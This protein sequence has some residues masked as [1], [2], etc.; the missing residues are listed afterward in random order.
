MSSSV[1]IVYPY[2][3]RAYPDIII[4][5]D[6]RCFIAADDLA[7]KLTSAG[8]KI[9]GDTTSYPLTVHSFLVCKL[10]DTIKEIAAERYPKASILFNLYGDED[11]SLHIN[12]KSIFSEEL[13]IDLLKV[14]GV[15]MTLSNGSYQSIDFDAADIP[16][17][18]AMFNQ[19]H[20]LNEPNRLCIRCIDQL[21]SSNHCA[22]CGQR[23]AEVNKDIENRRATGKPASILIE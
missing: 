20:R 6:D 14:R 23:L 2:L 18:M 5:G 8:F 15:K 11:P 21:K 10:D 9:N 19:L 1:L 17:V 22:D 7:A 16:K 12:T 3:D 13:I 4:R